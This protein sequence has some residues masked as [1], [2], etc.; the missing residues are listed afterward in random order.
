MLELGEYEGRA[1]GLGDVPGAGGDVLEECP[2][3]GEQ[4]EPSFSPEVTPL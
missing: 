1:D 2:S 3:L 4:G